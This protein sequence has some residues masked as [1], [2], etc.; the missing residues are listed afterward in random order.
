MLQ[1]PCEHYYMCSTDMLELNSFALF[2]QPLSFLLYLGKDMHILRTPKHV[3][4][5]L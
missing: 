1:L 3:I 5:R 2:V 4:S